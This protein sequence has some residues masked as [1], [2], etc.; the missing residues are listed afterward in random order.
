MIG[1]AVLPRASRR[2][3]LGPAAAVA[4]GVG[5]AAL[6]WY[7]NVLD[8]DFVARW[9]DEIVGARSAPGV[10]VAVGVAFVIGAAMVVLPCGFP[11]V[12][13][14][15]SILERERSTPGRARALAAYAAGGALPLAR[16]RWRPRARSWDWPAA[17]S[18]MRSTVANA[19]RSRRFCTRCSVWWPLAMR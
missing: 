16:C 17:V 5:L 15:P 13:A 14:V 3:V 7:T 9:G 18:G 1:A 12:L 4:L 19:R 6:F 11:A 10:A 2:R 8:A